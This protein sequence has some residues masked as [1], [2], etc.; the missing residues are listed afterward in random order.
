MT[1]CV[2]CKEDLRPEEGELIWRGDYC[3]VILIND[4]DLP[5][6]CRVIWN[7]HVS[8]M[9]DLTYGERDHILSLVF[10]VEEAIRQVMDP[11]KINLAALGNMVPH[12][13]WHV[14]PRFKDDAFFPGSA[15]SARA[16]EASKSV[17]EARRTLAKELPAAIRSAISQMH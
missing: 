8:E 14:I 6:F 16:Q 4:P 5:G 3:R 7:P 2:L 17:L 12:I 1:N 13:H 11:D 10:A 9:S 15:W